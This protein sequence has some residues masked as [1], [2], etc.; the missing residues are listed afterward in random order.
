MKQND[1]DVLSSAIDKEKIIFLY[2]G[3]IWQAILEEFV[4]ILE[5]N[6]DFVTSKKTSR[7]LLFIFTETAQ[8]FTAL[9]NSHTTQNPPEKIILLLGKEDNGF[10]LSAGTTL[11]GKTADQIS[12]KISYFNSLDRTK[13]SDE[14]R[15]LLRNG[16][17]DFF[18]DSFVSIAH[19]TDMAIDHSQHKLDDQNTFFSFQCHINSL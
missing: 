12:E 1:I 9:T 2:H 8:T 16:N 4:D 19:S 14:R 13:L 3:L 7:R 15:K 11:K 10:Y 17:H 6:L 18:L 5:E